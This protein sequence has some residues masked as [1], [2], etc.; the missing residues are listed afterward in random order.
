[1]KKFLLF[2]LSLLAYLFIGI[3]FAQ[4]FEMMQVS[5]FHSEADVLFMHTNITNAIMAVGL[6]ICFGVFWFLYNT[7]AKPKKYFMVLALFIITLSVSLID[8]FSYSVINDKE[9]II[10]KN[11][12][13]KA[14][15][16]GWL[17]VNSAS[18]DYSYGRDK[19]G[20]KY[21]IFKYYLTLNDGNKV[22]FRNSEEFRSYNKVISITEILK[23][24]GIRIIKTDINSEDLYLIISK[25]DDEYGHD[26]ERMF[27]ELYNVVN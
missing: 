22:S 10:K 1:M 3:F 26:T 12:A 27:R 23:S 8:I 18:I 17:E 5:L 14:K 24:K 13:E 21:M 6:L 7:R 16:Y 4:L 19:Y 25:Y 20:K 11:F 15:H 2:L 9:I